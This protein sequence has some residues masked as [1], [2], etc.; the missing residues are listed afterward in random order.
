MRRKTKV[1]LLPAL[2]LFLALGGCS[3][4]T[5]IAPATS[6]GADGAGVEIA[7]AQFSDVPV[8]T[9]AQMVVDQTLVFG[10]A[11][12]WIGRVVLT[13]SHDSHALFD[14]YKKELPGFGWSEI[15]S[16][17]AA[18]SNLTYEREERI[19]NILIES[20][21]LSG[22]T[23]SIIVSPRGLPATDNPTPSPTAPVGVR[24]AP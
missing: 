10:N 9:K 8:P 21:T 5:H 3:K 11:D 1:F 16:V 17:R 20:A 22:T 6:S 12:R 23:I 24:P 4:T 14:F 18:N 15:T 13:T 7:L 2:A 19:A